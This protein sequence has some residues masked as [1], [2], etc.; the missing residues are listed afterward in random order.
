MASELRPEG[1]EGAVDIHGGQGLQGPAKTLRWKDPG[2]LEEQQEA[3]RAGREYARE[4]GS[5]VIR[6]VEGLLGARVAPGLTGHR[7]LSLR[8]L[9]SLGGSV[10]EG[11]G[12][13]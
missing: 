5:E 3:I 10:L 12:P 8:E 6:Q 9:G 1:G 7:E 11:I 2:L 13:F 4:R